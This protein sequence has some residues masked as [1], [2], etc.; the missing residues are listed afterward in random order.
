MNVLRWLTALTCALAMML[1]GSASAGG[2]RGCPRASAEPPSANS[3]EP[4]G[5]VLRVTDH[6][7]AAHPVVA[8]YEH[9]TGLS[10]FHYLNAGEQ[11]V[12]HLVQVDSHGS[13]AHLWVRVEF[14]QS[15]TDI[16]L[17]IYD[18][19]AEQVAWSESSNEP[20]EDA[21]GNV[22]F[23]ESDS[24]GPGFENVNG[25]PVRRCASLTIETQNSR[26]VTSTP[27]KLTAWLG[28]AATGG[29]G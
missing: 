19:R 18:A 24:G 3:P 9:T 23:Y 4:T 2:A 6:N 29:H 15:P 11:L 16:D 8:S 28:P 1:T 26:V 7:D 25:L 21:V 10:G 12:D 17:Y 13:R 20:A 5:P 27:V 22:V 14:A